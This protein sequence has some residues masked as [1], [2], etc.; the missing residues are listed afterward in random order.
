ME[1]SQH[2]FNILNLHLD[3]NFDITNYYAIEF[4]EILGNRTPSEAQISAAENVLK[5]CNIVG[6]WNISESLH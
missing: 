4:L 2:T 5:A 6:L 1:N 3:E